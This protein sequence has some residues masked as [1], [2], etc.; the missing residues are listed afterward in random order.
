MADKELTVFIVDA[1]APKN[2]YNYLFHTIAGKLLKG[3]KTDVVSVIIFH[4]QTTHHA[5]ADTGKFKGINVMMDFE[6]P[7]YAQLQRLHKELMSDHNGSDTSSSTSD[8]VQSVLFSTTLVNKSKGKMFTRNVVLITYENTPL[9]E[10]SS[11]KI[12]SILKF[13]QDMPVN[14][15]S[16]VSGLLNP[17]TSKLRSL[18]LQFHKFQLISD[19][20]AEDIVRNHPPIKKVRPIS[21]FRGDLRLGADYHSAVQEPKYST[22]NE[23][24]CLSFKVDVYPAAKLEATS[25]GTHE[26]VVNDGS[27]V[28]L[29]RKTKYFVWKKNFQGEKQED[30]DEIEENDKNYDKVEVDKSQFTPGFKF[31]NFDLIALDD[32]LKDAAMLK[33]R[34]AFDILGF[35][36]RDTLPIAFMTG[37]SFLVVPEKESTMRNLV[38]YNSLCLA[39]LQENRVILARFVRKTESEVEVGALHPVQ[40]E[41]DDL[42]TNCLVYVRIPFKEDV[43]VGNFIRLTGKNVLK[44]QG[45]DGLEFDRVNSLMEEL[46]EEKTFPEEHSKI[47]ERLVISNPKICMKGSESS[48]LSSKPSDTRPNN[49]HASDPGINKF[50]VNIRKLLLKSLDYDDISD[51][52]NDIS[53]TEKHLFSSEETNLFNLQNVLAVN[54]PLQDPKILHKLAENSM[55]VSKRLAEEI[56]TVYVKKEEF[57]KRKQSKVEHYES[58]GNYGAEEKGYD[59]VPDFGL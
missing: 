5:S 27:I 6:Q 46:I 1:A 28:K 41:N 43:K 59:A 44:D 2:L 20:M 25:T 47:L 58:R 23:M 42:R 37:E 12:E 24:S 35:L 17:Q 34:S 33:I 4:S 53:N 19:F 36:D 15:Y 16:I 50:S 48:K 45:K 39:L 11:E 54:A 55:A 26:Y 3:L 8:F 10:D 40:I 38:A 14:M 49:F 7:S 29:E 51:F 57:K 9:H 31:S 32:D 22:E 13:L 30:E 56:G 21:V 18:E 52:N